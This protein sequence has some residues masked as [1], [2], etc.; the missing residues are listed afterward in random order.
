M[1]LDYEAE[2]DIECVQ[3]LGKAHVYREGKIIYDVML[4]Q[5]LY[6]K[7]VACGVLNCIF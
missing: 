2:V 6:I 4:N 5:V 1:F 3:K 7:L